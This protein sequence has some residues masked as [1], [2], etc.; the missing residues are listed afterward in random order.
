MIA[1]FV[2]VYFLPRWARRGNGGI[3]KVLERCSR[4]FGAVSCG[5]V[6]SSALRANIARF[7]V[8]PRAA[9]SGRNVRGA[10]P[11]KSRGSAQQGGAV[12][13]CKARSQGEGVLEVR[14]AAD[15]ATLREKASRSGAKTPA[16]FP[17]RQGGEV[18]A[19]PGFHSE[20]CGRV[21]SSAL[22]ANIARFFYAAAGRVG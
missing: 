14:R 19:P 4:F 5:G 9:R 3:V 2:W 20:P 18:P 1:S 7:F 11:G 17:T 21:S 22:C 8:R 15:D 16:I 13:S 6:S 10:A 12:F